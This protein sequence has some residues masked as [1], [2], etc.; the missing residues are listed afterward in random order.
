MIFQNFVRAFLKA[1]GHRYIKRIPYNTPKGRRYRYIYRTTSTHR[2]RHAFDEAHLVE[3][4]KF[5][6]HGEGESEFH[7]HITKVKGDQITYVIDDGPRKGEEVTTTRAK[8]VAELNDVHGV[9]DKLTAERA[10]VKE[11]IAEAKRAGHG[12]VVRRLERRLR[13]LGGEPEAQ[14]AEPV[15][16]EAESVEPEAAQRMRGVLDALSD[17]ERL[18]T[19]N[20]KNRKRPKEAKGADAKLIE[21]VNEL[22]EDQDPNERRFLRVMTLKLRDVEK[23]RN[24]YERQ[25]SRNDAF[26]DIRVFVEEKL[27]LEPTVTAPNLSEILSQPTAPRTRPSNIYG[28]A[29][30]DTVDYALSPRSTGVDLNSTRL[31]LPTIGDLREMLSQGQRQQRAKEDLRS[32]NAPRLTGDRDP[33]SDIMYAV[34]RYLSGP[35]TEIQQKRLKN[36]ER[37]LMI[38]LRDSRGEELEQT[39]NETARFWREWGGGYKRLIGESVTERTK[40]EALRNIRP[41]I[42]KR[43]LT[44]EVRR[45]LDQME[46]ELD[47]IP[48]SES[49]DGVSRQI[50]SEETNKA[51]RTTNN[52]ST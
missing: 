17:S 49:I 12:G 6:L 26:K 18:N 27:G 29:V 15:E 52:E 22:A 2:G 9:Q 3:G 35:Y 16:R 43:A 20:P 34:E 48:V 51:T 30:K 33:R 11:A 23:K 50:D 31:T 37:G 42:P 1:V 25:E 47:Q 19:I 36:M 7:G 24:A 44:P 41:L 21:L 13:A 40:G 4:T 46:N 8:L 10:K 39:K 32:V 28:R 5:A 38:A 45:L 14:P